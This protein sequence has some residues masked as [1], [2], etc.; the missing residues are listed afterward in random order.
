M[1]SLL[2]LLR[3]LPGPVWLKALAVEVKWRLEG[4]P[5]LKLGWGVPRGMLQNF[6]VRV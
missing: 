6:A 4:D 3:L 2:A 5:T 1:T